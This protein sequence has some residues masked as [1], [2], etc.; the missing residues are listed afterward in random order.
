[1]DQ[2]HFVYPSNSAHGLQQKSLG[3]MRGVGF[4]VG[5]ELLTNY[6]FILTGRCV[7]GVSRGCL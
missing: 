6:L 5:V 4:I 7:C 2:N 1:M 3:K